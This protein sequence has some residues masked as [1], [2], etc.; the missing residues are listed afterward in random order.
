MGENPR[1]KLFMHGRSQ[2]VRLPKE[3]RFEG[4]EVEVHRQGDSV[5]LTPVARPK[6]DAAAILSAM[7]SL[8]PL[9]GFMEGDR[10]EGLLPDRDV[11]F[12]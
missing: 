2:A 5:V 3:F 6:P 8:G 4:N 9:D 10:Y 11:S 7:A 1:A 12:D